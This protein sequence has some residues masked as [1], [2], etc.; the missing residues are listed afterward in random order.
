MRPAR[1]S[2]G[3]ADRR[4]SLLVLTDDGVRMVDAAERTFTE[5]V[6]ELI[7]GALD[8]TRAA[9]VA[10]ALALLRTALERDQ[11]GMPTG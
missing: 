7:E 4:S 8:R 11:I 5:R 6:T 9:A 1:G 10:E 2:T 3:P